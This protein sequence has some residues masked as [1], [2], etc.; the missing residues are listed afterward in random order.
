MP[1]PHCD[2]W[3]QLMYSPTMNAI[4]PEALSRALSR[5]VAVMQPEAVY[6]FGSR[7][8]GDARGD[9]DFDFLVLV[10]DD[11]SPEQKSLE[12]TARIQRDPGV[13]LDI[14]PCRRSVFERKRHQVGT[15]SYLVAR[16]GRLVYE[17]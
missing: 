14:V 6:L 7:A 4:Q 9:S 15:L 16:E 3:A 10:P 5:I 2:P 11:A 8:R 1:R 17:R 13:S 12:I